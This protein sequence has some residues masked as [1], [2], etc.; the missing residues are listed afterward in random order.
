[1][2][3]RK[4][5]FRFC[6]ACFLLLI[7][8]AIA[9]WVCLPADFEFAKAWSDLR[10]ANFDTA[11]AVKDAIIQNDQDVTAIGATRNLPLFNLKLSRKDIAHF[12]DLYEKYENRTN[13]EYGTA[14]YVQHNLWRNCE[15]EYEGKTYTVKV[16]SHGRSPT[17]HRNGKYIS[18]AVKMPR[19]ENIKG[20]RR[21]SFLVRDH[22]TPKKQ[23]VFDIADEF[24]VLKNQEE[25][26]RVKINNWDEKLYFFDRRLNDAFME[27]EGRPSLRLFSY[28]DSIESTNKSSVYAGG[29][30]DTV[31]CRARMLKTLAE[32]EYPESQHNAIADRFVA[33]NQAI[34][35]RREDLLLEFC[36]LEYISSFQAMRLASGLVGHM[37]RV[38]NLYVF[39]DTANGKF[40]PVVT[41]DAWMAKLQ[42]IEDGSPELFVDIAGP[43][44]QPL[45]KMIS[46]NEEVR[47]LA[48][49][50]LFNYFKQNKDTIGEKH[51]LLK[52]RF[53]KLSYIGW[54]TVG[55]RRSGLLKDDF[56][57]H[58]LRVSGYFISTSEPKV[59][60]TYN[61]NKVLFEIRPWS[62]SPVRAAKF[63]LATDRRTDIVEIPV[64]VQLAVRE[65]EEITLQPVQAR[66]VKAFGGRIDLTK[67]LADLD[68]M[69]AVKGEDS[70]RFMRIHSVLIQLQTDKVKL[71]N[72][73]VEALLYN[74]ITNEVIE[75]VESDVLFGDFDVS[76]FDPPVVHEPPKPSW[77]KPHTNL[78]L[79]LAARKVTLRAGSYELEHD[80]ILPDKTKLVIEAGTKLKLSEGVSIVSKDG[81]DVLGTKSQ[82]VKIIATDKPFGSI[83]VLGDGSSTSNISYLGIANGFER[84]VDGTY[85]S[86]GLS[87][88]YN[89]AVNITDSVFSNNTADDGLNI[90]YCNN[91]T[92]TNCTFRDN[93]ADQVDLDLCKGTVDGCK[94]LIQ[95]LKDANGDGLDLSGAQITV[96]RSQFIGLPDKGMSVGERSQVVLADNVFRSCTA[97]VAVK[98]L[99]SVFFRDNEFVENQV[100]V[101]A[102]QKKTMF[103]GGA[104]WFRTLPSE[105]KVFLGPK[106]KAFTA[107]AV[108]V[109]DDLFAA[110]EFESP[111]DLE[112]WTS[113]PST[114]KTKPFWRVVEVPSAEAQ[115]ASTITDG[116]ANPEAV[117][118]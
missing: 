16:K 23:V 51:R 88:H 42:P 29:E 104:A 30:F 37:S 79:E 77:L 9:I 101:D 12:V 56:T 58:N 40:Y 76:R 2:K 90:K 35:D 6:A 72:G 114:F 94:F 45:F 109:F 28:S 105:L 38:D 64:M 57:T 91:V 13:P 20:S 10:R 33:F 111:D 59:K 15:L 53:E 83:G 61:Q 54:A 60:V 70:Q 97:G 103:G 100:D 96:Q 8:A 47:K 108:G 4:L 71:A 36:D 74:G 67:A 43:W 66:T 82:P 92:L 31:K 18:L 84:W 24:G 73:A 17:H 11:T 3:I 25:L 113:V 32:L 117:V 107:N 22:F 87:I 55:L 50:K 48:Y 52:E 7:V 81:L 39:L 14:Y 63:T 86:G 5:I 62:L 26:V 34:V 21:F 69:T 95:E 102:F 93:A 112:A 75:A 80:L 99:S 89:G 46:H 41:R 85:F 49:A 106:S 1:M 118:E 116:A 98:D 19:G 65:G 44:G 78:R 27:V 68:F 115:E 110:K